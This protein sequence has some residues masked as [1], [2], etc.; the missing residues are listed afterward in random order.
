M[1]INTI[2][3]GVVGSGTI[4]KDSIK[5]YLKQSYNVVDVNET[6]DEKQIGTKV[7][8]LVLEDEHNY[9]VVICGNG[10]GIAK[11]AMINDKIMVAVCVNSQQAASARSVNDANII[12]LGHR[13]MSVETA[14]DVLD[15]FFKTEAKL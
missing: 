8:Q 15:T 1:K 10:F 2:Y 12:A 7:A 3:L 4:F 9:G 5:D 14:K 13:M 6:Y 11:E